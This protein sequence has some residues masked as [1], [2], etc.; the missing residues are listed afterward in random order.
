MKSPESS[1]LPNFILKAIKVR[2][3]TV[4]SCCREIIWIKPWP[5]GTENGQTELES[6]YSATKNNIGT[7]AFLFISISFLLTQPNKEQSWPLVPHYGVK[8][9]TKAA[10]PPHKPLRKGFLSRGAQ[11]ME[12]AAHT[13]PPYSILKAPN[14]VISTPAGRRPRDL[15]PW[16]IFPLL[17]QLI[18]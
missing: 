12:E 14:P 11:V 7:C 17:W 15:T 18:N 8:C 16:L 10:S 2:K 1:H 13:D 4:S 5:Q 3:I 9:D 6:G